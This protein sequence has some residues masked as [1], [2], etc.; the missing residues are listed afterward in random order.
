MQACLIFFN[1]E[2]DFRMSLLTRGV[3]ALIAGGSLHAD[4]DGARS[5]H[6]DLPSPW[7]KGA[8][9]WRLVRRSSKSEGASDH[10]QHPWSRRSL[11]NRAAVFTCRARELQNAI[12]EKREIKDDATPR[13]AGQL[14]LAWPALAGRVIPAASIAQPSEEARIAS[15]TLVAAD[16]AATPA[17]PDFCKVLGSIAPIDPAAQLINFEINLPVAWNRKA[18]QYGGGYKGPLITGLA[19]ARC[20]TR[21]SAALARGAGNGSGPSGFRICAKQHRP[22]RPQ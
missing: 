17:T 20:R 13:A 2:P 21:R 16:A 10:R 18:V 8:A 9:G 5:Y 7:Y 12:L 3:I 14:K 19:L 11:R 4:R 6:H 22:V 1:L 15:A